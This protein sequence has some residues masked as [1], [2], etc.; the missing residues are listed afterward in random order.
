MTE[1]EIK[2]LQEEKE[3][4]DRK[5]AEFESAAKAAREESEKARGDLE[6]VVEELKEE[7]QKKQDAL[8][9]LNINNGGQPTPNV[10]ELVEQA[11]TKKEQERREQEFK[12][13]IEEFKNSKT[14]FQGDSAGIVFEKFKQGMNRFNFSDVKNKA[15]AKQRLEEVYRFINN[16][17]SVEE[18]PE[19]EGSPRVPSQAPS[20]DDRLNR[21]TET[22]LNQAGVSQE[23]YTK[24]KS[25]YGDA[26]SSL[27]L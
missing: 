23:S 2:K 12:E 1:E 14:E 21:E 9:K 6:K 16:K 26:L 7:R 19:Y 27:G 25:K 5:L 10:D 13:A 8:Q 11:L 18:A 20:T 17:P 15:E 4:A 3:E 24:L 22:V